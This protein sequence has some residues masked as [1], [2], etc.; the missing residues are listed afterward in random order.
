MRIKLIAPQEQRNDGCLSSKT[1]KL[2]R[3]CL[4]LLAALAPPGH[5]IKIVDESFCPDNP[6]EDVDLVGITVITELAAYAYR[7][8]QA[9]R[10]KG[11]KVVMGGIHPTVLP[12][13]A[14]QYADSVVIGE[15][16]EVWPRLVNDAA[17]GRL[18]RIYRS[19]KTAN[20][21]GLPLPL[22]DLYPAPNNRGF[23]PLAYSVETGRGCP[24][25]CDF[26]SVGT[27]SGRHYRTRPVGD[28]IAEIDSFEF[29]YLFFVDDSL[30]LNRVQAKK[31]FSEMI[32]SRRLWVGQGGVGLAEDLE[33]LRLMR[34]SGC[35]GLLIGF[36]SVQPK[37]QENLKKISGLSIDFMESM[38][39]FHGE[40]IAVLGAFVFGFDYEDKDV[41]ERTLEFCLKARIDVLEFRILTP[42]PG[43]RFYKRLLEEGR[44]FAPDWWLKGLSF[45]TILYQPKGMS[46]DDLLEGFAYLNRHAYSYSAIFRRFWGMSIPRRTP[47]GAR[48]YAGVNLATRKR[49]LGNLDDL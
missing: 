7:L 23:A 4:P 47:V 2:Q 20:M 48:L 19:E 3:L 45:K 17:S 49:Y 37:S 13:E 8:A 40:G 32:P 46:I 38:R 16:E 36:E 11:V 22:R 30:A 24:F 21:R 18:Q 44:L 10:Q 31:L 29:P 27:I 1:F 42:F 35:M 34:R 28:I 9:Y 5:E 43:T 41:F 26:C 25:D 6:D 15:G 12:E 39:R 33:L 14:L